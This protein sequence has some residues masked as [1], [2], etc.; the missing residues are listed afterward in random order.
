AGAGPRV[1]SWPPE[2]QH[3][4]GIGPDQTEQDLDHARLAGPVRS[5]QAHHLAAADGEGHT[6]DRGLPPVALAQSRAPHR[7]RGRQLGEQ[8][9]R[10]IK[11]RGVKA[12]GVKSRGV[13]GSAALPGGSVGGHRYRSPRATDSTSPVLSVPATAVTMPSSTQTTATI[14]PS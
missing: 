9:A 3:L 10:V 2:Q 6:A 4:P 5:E 14:V 11:S 7:R 12:R 8:P 1:P 13:E